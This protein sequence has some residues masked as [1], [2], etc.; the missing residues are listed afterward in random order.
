MD[1]VTNCFD[2]YEFMSHTMSYEHHLQTIQ[3]P[4]FAEDIRC[5]LKAQEMGPT[6]GTKPS[7]Q[8]LSTCAAAKNI[9]EQI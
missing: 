8:L 4:R 6:S 2:P 1:S 5:S 7:D 3:H 9:K